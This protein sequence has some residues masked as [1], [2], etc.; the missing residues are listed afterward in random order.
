MHVGHRDQATLVERTAPSSTVLEANATE[1]HA[2]PQIELLPIGEELELA[3]IEPLLVTD[4][5]LEREPV[6]EVDE[7]LVSTT[8]PA[9]SVRSRL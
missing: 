9:M 7:I 8:R 5:N 4:A 1:Q 2:T 6:W 3:G